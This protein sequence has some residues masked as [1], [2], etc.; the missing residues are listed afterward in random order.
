MKKLI[1]TSVVILLI[2]SVT[3]VDSVAAKSPVIRVVTTYPV[4]D[5]S[6]VTAQAFA[7]RVKE[8]SQGEIEVQVFHS[9]SMGGEKDTVQAVKLGSIQVVTCGLL[10]V[11]MFTQDYA[12]FDGIYVFKDFEHFKRVW[13]G[14][15]GQGIKE[16][17]LKNNLRSM[18]VYQ[19]GVRQLGADK[20]VKTPAD[21]KGLKLRVPQIPSW[22]KVFQALGFLPTPVALSELFTALQ[23]GVVD[24]AEGP[25]SQMVSYKYNEVQEYLI[26]TSH[27]ISVA[28][29]LVN[30]RWFQKL[31]ADTRDIVERAAKEAI[32]AG[33]TYTRENTEKQVQQLLDGGMT[34]VEPDR[35]AFI[36]AARPALEE[37]F[38]TEWKVTSWD[39]V[40]SYAE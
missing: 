38:A 23:T 15:P 18:G 4:G 39:E 12:F 25:P 35:E 13:D 8:Y 26:M 10:P 2:F 19:R 9:G 16:I 11:T 33:A 37:L 32:E 1:V 29:L 7:E 40:M 36:E 24:C 6:Y 22:V 27:N 28:M 17:L 21:A 34:L 14:K 3:V 31:D 20:A 5:E 30:E